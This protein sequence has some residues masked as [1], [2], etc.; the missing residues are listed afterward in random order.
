MAPGTN[1]VVVRFRDGHLLKGTTYDFSPNRTRFHV[2]PVGSGAKRSTLVKI[3]AVK[4]VFFVKDLTGR[5]EY[6]EK[7]AFDSE[8]RG[9][10]AR[11]VFKDGEEL[12]G[13]TTGY[14]PE[15][16]GFFLLPVDPG[17]NNERIFVVV[18]SV[19]DLR[20]GHHAEEVSDE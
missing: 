14:S 6:V 19:K 2:Q 16:K 12:V 1:H 5:N 17:S 3:D 7:K 4:A 8:D 18:D 10:K 9:V 11:V 15:R 20:L 13:T